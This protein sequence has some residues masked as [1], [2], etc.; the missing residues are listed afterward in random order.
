MVRADIAKQMLEKHEK[1][2]MHEVKKMYQENKCEMMKLGDIV[3]FLNKSK[4]D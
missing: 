1:I 3:K 4:K 2:M